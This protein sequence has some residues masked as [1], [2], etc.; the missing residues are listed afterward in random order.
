MWCG[1]SERIAVNRSNALCASLSRSKHIFGRPTVSCRVYTAVSRHR[2]ATS[3]WRHR[4]RSHYLPPQPI[5]CGQSIID[6]RPYIIQMLA[7][8]LRTHTRYCEYCD[9][10]AALFSHLSVRTL[11]TAIRR[12]DARN[13]EAP[14]WAGPPR[15][16]L[17]ATA[18]PQYRL[19]CRAPQL[20]RQLADISVL[21]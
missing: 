7:G 3:S 12:H 20:R 5:H 18:G 21:R 4:A 11:S 13:R 10:G 9:I 16:D 1:H 19:R 14:R 6:H 2:D 15:P 8:E 17:R